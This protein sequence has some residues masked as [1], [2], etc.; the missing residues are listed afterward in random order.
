MRTTYFTDM[1]N[2]N[3]KELNSTLDLVRNSSN[4]FNSVS[5][6]DKAGVVRSTSPY[7]QASVGH[8]VSSNAKKKKRLA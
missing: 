1:D 8:H 2:S 6:V 5:L 4:F 3:T 7:S